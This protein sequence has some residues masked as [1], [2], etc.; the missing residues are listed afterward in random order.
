MSDNP[1]K[2]LIDYRDNF[3]S[4]Q[5]FDKLMNYAAKATYKY[6]ESDNYT[7]PP[8]GMVHNIEKNSEIWEMLTWRIEELCP[9]VQCYTPFKISINCFAPR[10]VPYFHP[11]DDEG[12]VTFI[13]YINPWKL[14]DGGC[15]EIFINN[16]IRAFPPLPNRMVWFDA[17]LLHRATT[18]RDDHRFAYAIKYI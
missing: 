8:T 11:D 5:G 2:N 6:G 1:H 3:F 10:E 12:G 17:T 15:T 9:F 16:E 18:R 13:Y 7:T 14:D 4:D